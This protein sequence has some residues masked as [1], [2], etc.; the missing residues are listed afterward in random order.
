MKTAAY[1]IIGLLMPLFAASTAVGQANDVVFTGTVLLYGSGANVRTTT[2][3]FTFRLSGQ[4][5][6][7]D[8]QRFIDILQ[9]RGQTALLDAIDGQKVGTFAFTGQVAR[10]VNVA[11]VSEVDGKLRIRAAFARWMGMGELRGG[12][13]SIDYPFSYVE[14]TVDPKSGKGDGT[15]ISAAKVRLRMNDGKK[16]IEVEDFGTFPGMVMAVQMRGTLV[17]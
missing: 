14:L 13:R 12:Y 6:D 5:S 4:T 8:G 3:T 10:D 7:E 2:R 15:F 17:P 9:D 11:R 16:E 1:L